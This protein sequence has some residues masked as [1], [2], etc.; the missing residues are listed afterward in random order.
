MTETDIQQLESYLFA[1]R[2]EDFIK[3]LISGTDSFYY[4]TLL[5][6]INKYGI[7]LSSEHS[8]YLEKYKKF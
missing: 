6:A 1:E 7:N 4:F 3:N 2:K 8:A 5:N